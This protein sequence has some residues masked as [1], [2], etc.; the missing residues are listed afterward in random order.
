MA[1]SYIKIWD[2][3]ESYFEPLGAAEVGRLVLA[4]MKYKSSGVEPEFSGSEKF[5]WPA[6]R[7]DLDEDAAYTKKKSESG[8]SGGSASMPSTLKQTKAN[9]SKAKQ[10]EADLSKL[11]QNEATESKAKQMQANVSTLKQTEANASMTKDVGLRT[12]DIGSKEIPPDGGIKK[13]TAAA[14]PDA[15]PGLA[16]IIR[17]FEDNIGVFPPAARESLLQWRQVFTDDL[18]LRAI[19]EASLSGVRKWTYVNG[20]LKAWKN[21]GV[22]TLGDVQARDQRRKPATD[23]LSKRSAAEDYDFIFGGSNDT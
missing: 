9:A 1:R 21:D 22:K 12:K 23:Q 4:M 8:R 20:V 15:D 16:E 19:K 2:S 18:I 6:I 3:Y 7:R 14:N 5:I 13:S 17:S 10:T 11:K